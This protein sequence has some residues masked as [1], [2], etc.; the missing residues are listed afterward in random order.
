MEIRLCKVI[1]KR[2]SFAFV[3]LPVRSEKFHSLDNK[4]VQDRAA[5][6]EPALLL[7]VGPPSYHI[8]LEKFVRL[9]VN[10]LS[11]CCLSGKSGFS[12]LSVFCSETTSVNGNCTR[13][14]LRFASAAHCIAPA[15][16]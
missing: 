14:R 1:N 6:C 12:A 9:T 10:V 16:Q 4:M 13:Q 2:A 8:R 3:S 5:L 7:L 15:T 11:K